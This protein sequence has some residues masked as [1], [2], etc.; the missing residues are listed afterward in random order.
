MGAPW[1]A[2]FVPR[3]TP[4]SQRPLG[5]LRRSHQRRAGSRRIHRVALYI[6]SWFSKLGATRCKAARPMPS[7]NSPQRIIARSRRQLTSWTDRCSVFSGSGS[8]AVGEE[9]VTDFVRHAGIDDKIP[10]L[11][12]PRGRATGFFAK[13]LP[14]GVGRFE[15]PTSAAR[16]LMGV[17]STRVAVLSNQHHFALTGDGHNHHGRGHGEKRV[18]EPMVARADL[19]VVLFQRQPTIVVNRPRTNFFYWRV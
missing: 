13:F 11:P 15:S 2:T 4:S 19:Y 9:D 14:S 7:R 10:Q 8:Q 16:Q 3:T 6:A 5:S 17:L 18:A 12:Q 1:N